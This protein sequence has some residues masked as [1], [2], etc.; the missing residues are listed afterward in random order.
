MRKC[1]WKRKQ[2]KRKMT[3][4]TNV[5]VEWVDFVFGAVVV[6]SLYNSF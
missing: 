4:K 6:V 2:R 5:N 1:W 3:V